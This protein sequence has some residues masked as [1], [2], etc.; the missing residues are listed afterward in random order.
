[1]DVALLQHENGRLSAEIA[2]LVELGKVRARAGMLAC[3]RL[4]V[5]NVHAMWC[6]GG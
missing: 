5:C 2:S 1:M 6:V 4:S 3:L